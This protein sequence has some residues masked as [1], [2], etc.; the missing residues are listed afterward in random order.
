MKL[1][2]DLKTLVMLISTACMLAGLYYTTQARLDSI[3]HQVQD[4]QNDTKRL[5]KQVRNIK[6]ERRD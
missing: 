6:K 4:L 3:E 2:L 1:N 5:S